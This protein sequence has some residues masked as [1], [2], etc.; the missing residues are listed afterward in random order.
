MYPG[1]CAMESPIIAETAKLIKTTY[2]KAYPLS[3]KPYGITLTTGE[4]PTWY[5][6]IMVSDIVANRWFNS[7]NNSMHFAYEHNINSPYTYD[8]GQI[9]EKESWIGYF[10]PRGVVSLGY[11]LNEMNFEADKK[12]EFLRNLAP[13]L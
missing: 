9:N 6:K 7:K 5:S 10:Y 11:F 12:E 13:N 1:F 4:T 2:E 8:D 3:Q